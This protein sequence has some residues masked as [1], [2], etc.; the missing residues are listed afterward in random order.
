MPPEA[1]TDLLP[2]SA[3]DLALWRGNITKARAARKA[4][5][6][7]AVANLKAYAPDLTTDPDDYAT[8]V[9]PNRDFTLVER[10]KADLFYQKPD[11]SCVASPLF[12]GQEA[13]LET[14]TALLNEKLGLNGVQAK[15][16]VH[17]TLFDVLCPTGTGWTI[18]GYDS[19]TQPT[20]TPDP[21][22]PTGVATVT[23]QVPVFEDCFWR[24]FSP[25]C[26]LK[27]AEFRSTLWDDAP[28]LGMEF[29]MPLRL[30]K[31]KGWVPQDHTG[32]PSDPELYFE[33]G[34]KRD[35]T[36]MVVKGALIYYKSAQ[37][38]DDQIHPL[39][40]TLLV[41]IEGVETPAEHKDSPYQT[42]DPQG[43]L[44][45]DSLIGFPIHPLTIR[46]L[47]DSSDVPSD[48]TISRPLANELRRFREQMV[49]QR[50]ANVLR[51]MYN[52]DTLPTDALSKIVRSPI[53]GFI[54]VPGDAFVGDGGIKELPHGTYPRENFQFNDYLDNDMARTHGI[55]ADQSGAQQP[56]DQTATEASIKQNNVNARGGFE[57]GVV[58]DWYLAA[59]TKY[60]T[61]M[62]RFL[63]V[64]EAATIVGP[65]KAQEWDGWR[66]T[67]PA[68]LAF[69][70]LPDSTL[71]NDLA[72]DRKQAMDTYSYFA[73]DTNVNRVEHLKHILPTLRL[74]QSLIQ[75]PPPK[76]PDPAKPTFSFKGDD[77]NPLAPQFPI[78]MEILK[79][80]GVTVS[81]QAV[82]EAQSGAT[83]Q[84]LMQQ[85]PTNDTGEGKP[86]PNAEH[87]GKMPQA[88]SL[89]KH[90]ADLTGG[91]QGTGQVIR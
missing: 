41:L 58:L 42:L 26:A 2:L 68:S 10:K 85:I 81:P 62:Q 86:L 70:A 89:D 59:V 4:T 87:G 69:T 71:R 30:A 17:Q 36:E 61:L 31:R 55:D 11:V 67:V 21:A 48:C 9:N 65:Q 24:N 60:S 49:E 38:R 84:A 66:H 63:P 46:V 19:A 29:E 32:S 34:T 15:R 1:R 78:V 64:Q 79:Q 12:V 57:R 13:L 20:E 33:H 88:E 54:G 14:H 76:G 44:T 3:D 8:N 35:G 83:N 27:P 37:Y 47:T 23:A 45:P 28:W 40:Q 22:D 50:D 52:V 77:L 72:S 56:G 5:M 43:K 80:A 39:H 90:Q 51:W 91:M 18:M 74:P 25:K 82:A 53:G 16:L 6:Q 75:P 7:W 73:N